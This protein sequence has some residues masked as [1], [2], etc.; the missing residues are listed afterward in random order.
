MT[1]KFMDDPS[2]LFKYVAKN[3]KAR[4]GVP[5]LIGPNGPTEN[6]N[7]TADVLAEYYEEQLRHKTKTSLTLDTET[8]LTA[9]TVD[10]SSTA[11][12]QT[13]LKLRPTSPGPD[14]IPPQALTASAEYLAAPLSILY[15]KS[16]LDAQIPR[17]WKI[18]HITPIYKG[19]KRESPTNYRPITLLSSLSKVLES[20]VH[21]AITTYLKDK[22]LLSTQQHGFRS[23]YSCTTNLLYTQD[24]WTKL[25]TLI[26]PLILSS[27]ISPR[28]LTR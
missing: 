2:Y 18:G 26:T 21:K 27:S 10:T 14:G 4:S 7:E 8:S 9:I 22:Q 17:S 1:D 28:H 5:Q 16:M 11:V 15:T 12:L 3:T 19:G 25:P 24:Q 6:D 20:L 23:G 13:L